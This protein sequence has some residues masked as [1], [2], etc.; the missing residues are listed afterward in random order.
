M[1]FR[2]WTSWNRDI[3]SR[4][5]FVAVR[6][7]E[8]GSG[9]NSQSLKNGEVSI[10][11]RLSENQRKAPFVLIDVPWQNH[12]ENVGQTNNVPGPFL[13]MMHGRHCFSLAIPDGEFPRWNGGGELLFDLSVSSAMVAVVASFLVFH[14]SD[15]NSRVCKTYRMA[16][17][18]TIISSK[19]GTLE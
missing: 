15:P 1:K 17:L 6:S 7:L 10:R 9:E 16:L 11:G 14:S 4:G 12:F 5:L 19:S 3:K 13:W 8:I 2:V 18:L